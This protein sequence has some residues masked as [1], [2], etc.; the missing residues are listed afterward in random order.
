MATKRGP[1]QAV[2]YRWDAPGEITDAGRQRGL[3]EGPIGGVE[4][5]ECFHFHEYDRA[6][7]ARRRYCS[8]CR[9]LRLDRERR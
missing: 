3:Y 5:L 8:D 9:R 2:I 7:P 4:L 1:S 6:Y